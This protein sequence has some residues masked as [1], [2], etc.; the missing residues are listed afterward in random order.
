MNEPANNPTSSVPALSDSNRPVAIIDGKEVTA[1]DAMLRFHTRFAPYLCDRQ[2][3]A[4][5]LILA[6]ERE[7][8]VAEKVGVCRMTLWRWR[9]DCHFRW[10][11][12]EGRELVFGAALDRLRVLVPHAVD[13]LQDQLEAGDAMA[14]Y[15]FLRLVRIERS[16]PPDE[17]KRSGYGGAIE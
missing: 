9:N 4:I 16:Q 15:R 17:S 2:L 13:R 6:G 12:A 7:G 14:P 10:A 8:K 3:R 1:S 5:E 11:L